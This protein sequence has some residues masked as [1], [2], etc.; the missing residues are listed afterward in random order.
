MLFPAEAIA[1]MKTI[2]QYESYIVEF[3]F[4][5]STDNHTL[6]K[7]LRGGKECQIVNEFDVAEKTVEHANDDK[8]DY[9]NSWFIGMK[10]IPLKN[11]FLSKNFYF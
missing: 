11:F 10:A 1:M 7:H 2:L 9:I 4:P 8:D 6:S 5:Q 3:A